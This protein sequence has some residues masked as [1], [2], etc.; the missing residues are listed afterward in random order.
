MLF[1]RVAVCPQ[2]QEHSSDGWQS[3]GLRAVKAKVEEGTAICALSSFLEPRA[4][5]H[6]LSDDVEE[7]TEILLE[8]SR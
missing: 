5:R 1:S 4:T 8:A 6:L 7:Q 2:A 3:L